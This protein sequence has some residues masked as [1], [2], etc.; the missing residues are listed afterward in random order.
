MNKALASAVLG[1]VVLLGLPAVS[2]AC[3]WGCDDDWDC[4]GWGYD[5]GWGGYSYP[6]YSPCYS[7]DP[8][9]YY[10][11]TYFSYSPQSV[12]SLVGTGEQQAAA[13]K[14]APADVDMR[15]P[16]NAE[17]WFEGGKTHQTGSERHFE[18]P[19][20]LPGRSYTY[21]VRV[22]WT[23]ADGLVTD[24][25][26]QVKV[27]AS[28]RIMVDFTPPGSGAVFSSV[29]GPQY[30]GGYY[31]TGRGSF[32]GYYRVGNVIINGRRWGDIGYRYSHGDLIR[33]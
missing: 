1:M 7:Y 6:C 14:P 30:S 25:T 27:G 13:D 24:Q 9:A 2:S 8:C 11:P 31:R 33:W 20:L 3:G 19:D 15:V 17:V 21:D 5:C 12:I 18:S 26:R 4:D 23:S 32:S 16:A 28:Q 22:R 29:V 10:P